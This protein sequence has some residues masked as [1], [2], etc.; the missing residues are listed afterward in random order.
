MQ[1]ALPRV[2]S[3]GGTAI[4]MDRF[5]STYTMRLDA[6]GRVSVPA[7]YRTILA[8]DGFEG[9]YCLPSIESNAIDGGGKM[10]MEEI[11]RLIENLPLYSDGR[12][13][14]KTALFGSAEL[15]RLDPEGR[16]T[17]SETLKNHAGIAD[18]AVFV[19]LGPK[20]QIWEPERFRAHLDEAKTRVRELRRRLGNLDV[21]SRTTGARE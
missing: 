2:A 20:F 17:L 1:R 5:V 14:M 19:G 8:K 13:E 15:L 7:P 4:A 11:D 6:K 10:L 12:D 21:A 16:V 18:A 3:N 9:A